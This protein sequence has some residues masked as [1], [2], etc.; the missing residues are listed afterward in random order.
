MRREILVIQEKP[1]IELRQDKTPSQEIF[2]ST[3]IRS[4][5]HTS[6]L[7]SLRHL[8][9]RLLLEKKILAVAMV[10]A[11]L[12]VVR[13]PDGDVLSAGAGTGGGTPTAG[14]GQ[15]SARQK[16]GPHGNSFFTRSGTPPTSPPSPSR[17]LS[18]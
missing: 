2:L 17:T 10:G 11:N 7:Q 18:Q 9:C 3:G 15:R 13:V 8:V 4:E 12:G 14:A 6:E 1:K 5:E 16:T